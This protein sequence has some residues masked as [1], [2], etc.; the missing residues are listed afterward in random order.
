MTVLAPEIIKV[1]AEGYEHGWVCVRPPC[2]KAPG[3]VRAADLGVTRDGTVVHR[4][5]GYAVGHVKR[6]ESGHGYTAS[7][8]TGGKESTHGK[9]AD[10]VAAVARKHNKAV[11]EQSRPEPA[12]DADIAP[13]P[14]SMPPGVALRAKP[15]TVGHVAK[16]N[17]IAHV[18]T[19]EQ[20]KAIDNRI[21]ALEKDLKDEKRKESRTDIAIELGTVVASLGLAF[22]TS[23][24][25]LLGLLPLI[26]D[27]IPD[28]GRIFAKTAVH[29]RAHGAPKVVAGAAM[30]AR[31]SLGKVPG[32][33]AKVPAVRLRVVK[34]DGT[35]TPDA[36]AEVAKMIAA[37]LVAGGLDASTAGS[38]ALAMTSH[39]AL[40]LRA[41]KFPGDNDFI[42]AD[43]SPS[44]GSP[45]DGDAVKK[46]AQTAALSS[47]HSPLGTHGLWGDK[48]AQLPAYLQNIAKALIRSGHDESSAIAMAIGA[49]KRW[50]AGRGKV[51]PEVRAAAAK[52]LAEWEKLKAEHSK[53]KSADEPVV[54]KTSPKAGGRGQA[55]REAKAVIAPA[56]TKVGAEGYIHGWICVR[57]PC[58]GKPDKLRAKDLSTKRDGTI[59]HKPSGYAVGHVSRSDHGKYTVTH[60]DGHTSVHTGKD[61]A[62]RGVAGHYNSGKTKRDFDG[63]EKPASEAE[64]PEAAK[65][66][67]PSLASEKPAGTDPVDASLV[68][69]KIPDLKRSKLSPAEIGAVKKYTEDDS[70]GINDDLR[71]GTG[72]NLARSE[73]VKQLDSAFS[74]TKPLNQAIIV[75]RGI[76]RA[77]NPGLFGN[78]G[79]K[80]GKVFHDN[81]F[82]STTA[83]KTRVNAFTGSASNA[84][85]VHITVPAGEKVIRPGSSADLPGEKELILPRGSDFRVDKDEVDRDGNRHV[86]MTK[87]PAGNAAT[88]PAARTAAPDELRGD[89]AYKAVRPPK[90][91]TS[92]EDSALTRYGFTTGY[93]VVNPYLHHDGQVFDTGK[94]AYR[95]ARPAEEAKAKSIITGMDSAFNKAT[96]L[97]RPIVVHRGTGN[98]DDM[99][100][101]PGSLVGKTFNAKAYTSTTTVPSAKVGN[102]LDYESKPG[103]IE[104]HVPAGSKVLPGNDFE[105]E[106]I[107]PR[108]A[109]FHVLSDEVDAN[110]HRNIKLAYEPS[111]HAP[112]PVPA[113]EEKKP[114]L[115]MRSRGAV[116][117]QN[118]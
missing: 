69:G 78:V 90:N 12:A 107:L 15:A 115:K 25:S 86:Y 11:K 5:S 83:S 20:A 33:L 26:H 1:G 76:T 29:I 39:A 6:S 52:A 55:A 62:L 89:D 63:E 88:N 95:K 116:V 4:P 112:A 80:V 57:P 43:G 118:R 109:S 114:Q 8:V 94:M 108:D 22:F 106:V 37:E 84:A 71:F 17:E 79:D 117:L 42:T 104:I 75:H 34:T 24:A 81:G 47:T 97:E 99:F 27:R 3:R 64:A 40:A 31:S 103:K 100:G 110:G 41:G 13:P 23:G 91:L 10:A 19:D 66:P 44:D 59:L 36:V 35:I 49:V 18:Y 85:V 68:L 9:R 14:P 105:K 77:D 56:I 30:G 38:M 51:T 50:A 102:G 53:S 70:Y 96:P 58:G 82:V 92:D 74:H 46:S 21:T 60:S 45:S 73:T 113:E 93:T 2:G 48:S 98:V 65:K 54:V 87:L 111:S 61:A 67:S 7:H 28:I 32:A 72:T 16:A 101:K